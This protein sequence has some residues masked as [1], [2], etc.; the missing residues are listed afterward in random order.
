MQLIHTLR[1]I[2]KIVRKR[3]SPV[4]KVKLILC[5]ARL[6]LN[7][8]R[9]HY[10]PSDSPL[11]E[12]IFSYRIRF[13]NFPE[14][15]SLFEEIFIEEIYFVPGH[16]GRIVDCGSKIGLSIL[17]FKLQNPSAHI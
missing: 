7:A 1:V 14:L 2:L 13:F 15:L 5:Y 9:Q 6:V 11:F 4:P 12:K 16:H 10:L 3:K 17:Y 8:Y